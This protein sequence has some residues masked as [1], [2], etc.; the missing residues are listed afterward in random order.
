MGASKAQRAATAARREQA[1]KLKIAGAD[2]KT[3]ANRLGYASAAAACK[4]VTRALEQARAEMRVG[5]ETLRDIDLERL[6]RLQLALWPAASRGDQKV[7]DTVLRIMDRRAKWTGFDVPPEV[8]QRI[9][10]EVVK[11]IAGQMAQVWGR[12]LAGIPGLTAEQAA[13][14][15]G[16]LD[17]AIAAVVGRG[18]QRAIEGQVVDDEAAA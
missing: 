3:I 18:A 6:D 2:W 15:P 13:A 5:L 17:A 4:D 1:I 9:R 10:A 8:E 14:V 12:V 16:L 11:S 7:A